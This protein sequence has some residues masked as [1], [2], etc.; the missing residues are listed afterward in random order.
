MVLLR[1]LLIP[2]YY[3]HVITHGSDLF[4]FVNSQT[5]YDFYLFNVFP[6]FKLLNIFPF[7][8]VYLNII[9]PSQTLF[10]VWKHVVSLLELRKEESSGARSFVVGIEAV[11]GE[12]FQSE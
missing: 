11:T 6:K 9:F 8:T 10:N 3:S 12:E 5:I 2:R 4:L 1:Q 7:L